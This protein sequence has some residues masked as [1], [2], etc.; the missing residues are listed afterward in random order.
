MIRAGALYRAA[1]QRDAQRCPGQVCSAT[2]VRNNLTGYSQDTAGNLTTID[3][4][5]GFAP[6]TTPAPNRCF[7]SLPPPRN[8]AHSASP[9]TGPSESWGRFLSEHTTAVS[10]LN[11]LLHDCHVVV[12]DAESYRLRE[13]RTRERSRHKKS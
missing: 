11:R 10:M 5:L 12:A 8:V 4:P 7:A 1:L 6:S 9:A 13:A 3:H 2:D